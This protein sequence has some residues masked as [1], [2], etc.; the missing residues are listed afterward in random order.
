MARFT[1]DQLT[2]KADEAYEPLELHLK[3][4][5]VARFEN[6]IRLPEDTQRAVLEL[7]ES[8]RKAAGD[9]E[10]ERDKDEA[11]DLTKIV[12]STSDQFEFL[13]KW[14]ALMVPDQAAEI[15]ESLGSDIGPYLYAF[16]SW[17]TSEG[18]EGEASPSAV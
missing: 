5:N 13:K 14:V 16:D 4:G 2:E 10:A 8:T 3:S 17:S 9:E 6:L 1:I 11:F 18:P 7:I 12:K 15:E